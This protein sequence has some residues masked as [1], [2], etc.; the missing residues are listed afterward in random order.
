MEEIWKDVLEYEG[1]YEVSNLG[2]VRKV[3]IRKPYFSNKGYL[4]VTL[5]K[6]AKHKPDNI[7]KLVYEAFH[8]KVPKGLIIHHK[9]A[10]RANPNL[11]N[12]EVVTYSENIR[13]AIDCGNREYTDKQRAASIR[14]VKIAQM[15]KRLPVV[16]KKD[17]KVI[18]EFKSG[19]EAARFFGVG[20]N[21][22]YRALYKHRKTYK[23]FV[24][25]YKE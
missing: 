24:W 6:N 18:Y 5:C 15:A 4:C 21:I 16:A 23:G 25:D 9:D 22:I 19:S 1:L 10:N 3:I 20:R 7:H 2:R 8:G 13:A 12:L 11:D 14:N 17:G